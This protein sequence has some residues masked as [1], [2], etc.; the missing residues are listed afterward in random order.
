[1]MHPSDL[2][3]KEDVQR[4]GTTVFGLP[5]YHFKYIGSARNI[6]GRHGSRGVASDAGRCVAWSGRI[7][8]CQLRR[9]RNEHA[10]GILTE[11]IY[12]G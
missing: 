11:R 3:L 4:V 12:T 6:R 7:L 5:L 1:M 9:A 8:S 10:T 2:R